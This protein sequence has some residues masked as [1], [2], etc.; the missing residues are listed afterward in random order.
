[1]SKIDLIVA[2]SEAADIPK[3]AAEKAVN[4]FIDHVMDNVAKGV[5]V[6][7]PGFGS[8]ERSPRAARSGRDPQSG[9]TIQIAATVVPKFKAGKKF[10]DAVKESHTDSNK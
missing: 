3:N 5:K 9:K 6:A 7:L 1:M 8:W 10:K 4:A 2:V